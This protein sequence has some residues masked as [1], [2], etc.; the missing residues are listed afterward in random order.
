MHS[1][2]LIFSFKSVV[3]AMRSVFL[4][5]FP[6][7]LFIF[8]MEVTFDLLEGK[9]VSGFFTAEFLINLLTHKLMVFIYSVVFIVSLLNSFS[10]LRNEQKQHNK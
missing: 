10:T 7:I 1:Y 4:V 5:T 3:K 6:L 8:C 9:P 2:L